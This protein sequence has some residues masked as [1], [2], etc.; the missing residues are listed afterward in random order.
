MGK[1]FL[2]MGKSTSGKDSIYKNLIQDEAL[3]LKK[4]VPY[5]TRPMRDG[6]VDGVQYFFK[7]EDDFMQLRAAKKIIE[8]RTYHTKY[9]EWRYFTVDD[10]Q[11]DLE[12]GNYL[13]IGTLES[14]CSFRDYFD[15][16]NVAGIPIET[17]SVCKDDTDTM[18]AI[19]KAMSLGYRDIV[20]VCALGSRFDH[21]LAN[22]QS[23]AYIAEHG[24]SCELFGK[25]EH[26][27]TLCNGSIK[28]PKKE[29][30]SLSLFSLTDKCEGISIKGSE[31]DCEN[32]TLTNTFPLGVSNKWKDDVVTV[33]V[34]SGILL[35]VESYMK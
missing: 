10:G 22:I 27:K 18:L 28:L 21:S 16:E 20:I 4:V 35:T 15:K 31:Y 8:E 32:V 2:L 23:M 30:C 3:K 14:Y 34:K 24:G 11:I 1:I 5:T 13:V 6:E 7:S 29:N 9:G 33:S 26:L 19:K 12:N 17:F 25:G